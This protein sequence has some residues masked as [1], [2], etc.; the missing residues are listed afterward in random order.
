L[1]R[2]ALGFGLP[3]SQPAVHP[4][5]LRSR[6]RRPQTA[7]PSREPNG[8]HAR[9]APISGRPGVRLETPS[10]SSQSSSSSRTYWPR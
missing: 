10:P 6:I 2:E 5:R 9:S 4:S 1:T 8:R 3:W 7:A